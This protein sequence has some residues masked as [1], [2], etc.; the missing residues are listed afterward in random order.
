MRKK[1]VMSRK[2]FLKGGL[3]VLL[4]SALTKLTEQGW[5]EEIPQNERDVPERGWEEVPLDL[6]PGF[7]LISDPEN[8]GFGGTA[9]MS[10]ETLTQYIHVCPGLELMLSGVRWV[11]YSK[12]LKPNAVLTMKQSGNEKR[13]L[14]TIPEGVSYLRGSANEREG[15]PRLWV[16]S[17]ALYAMQ[18]GMAQPD[19]SAYAEIKI[20]SFD[21]RS[22]SY[23]RG[24]KDPEA[25]D[26]PS[27]GDVFF[28]P[29]G[30]DLILT[31][32]NANISPVLYGGENF[33]TMNREQSFSRHYYPGGAWYHCKT[34]KLCNYLVACYETTNGYAGKLTL[35]ALEAAQP[36]LYIRFPGKLSNTQYAAK[37]RTN[38]VADASQRLF[39]VIH[40]TDIHGDIDS[41]HAAY[42]YADQI[43]ANFV[44]LTG[45]CAVHQPYHGYSFIH[46]IIKDARTPTVYSC[47][48][49]DVSGITD[50]EAYTLNIAPIR[51]VL[52][53]SEEHPYYYRDLMYNGGTVRA[54][55]L[56]PFYEKAKSREKGYYTGEQLQWLCETLASTPDGGHVFILR[57][58]SHQN[59]ICLNKAEGMFYDYANSE[60]DTENPWLSMD[61]DPVVDIIDAYREKREITGQYTGYL[62][63]GSEVIEV[64]YSFENRT[65]SEFV[66][67]LTGHVHID[68]VGYARSA[69]TRQAV[70]GS[71]CT[72]GIKGTE[73]YYA[74]TTLAN[75]RDYGTDTQIAVN[76]FAFDFN[77]KRIYVARVGSGAHKDHEKTIMEL[78][79]Q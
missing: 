34:T 16:R 4:G 3:T 27:I 33:I 56:Y 65:D 39:T 38:G 8:K 41:A 9:E 22:R 10:E 1:I 44:A 32:Q 11:G 30:T 6:L 59:P 78:D 72:T 17:L 18:T 60:K 20:L 63:T 74:F 43:G 49:H 29:A 12:S 42:E 23:Y 28:A 64:N 71:L 45:D 40:L 15:P 77:K 5:A 54:I 51:D 69:K 53:A 66:A 21:Q 24:R 62:E 35:E 52:K 70:L 68:H 50:R 14:I 79:Y 75:P 46:S 58:F 2:Q 67:Y 7:C 73:D 61:R 36:H 19:V 26:C 47:G 76:V 55:S 13:T 57:H 48:N 25:L 37:I 31:V